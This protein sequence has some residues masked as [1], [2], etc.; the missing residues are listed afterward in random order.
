MKAVKTQMTTDGDRNERER[1]VGDDR[2]PAGPVVVLLSLLHAREEFRP[3]YR[4]RGW[5]KTLRVPFIYLTVVPK[6]SARARARRRALTKPRT[7]T[8]EH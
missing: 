8:G 6:R 4:A 3:F 2:E 5:V 1:K 7:P